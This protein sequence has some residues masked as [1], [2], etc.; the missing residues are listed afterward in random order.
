MLKVWT[1]VELFD[2]TS[3]SKFTTNCCQHD[4]HQQQLQHQQVLSWQF[5]TPGSHQSSLLNRTELVR[6]WVTDKH[7]QWSDSGPIKTNQIEHVYTES[8]IIHFLRSEPNQI[9]WATQYVVKFSRIFV[10]HITS[11]LFHTF[12]RSLSSFYSCSYANNSQHIQI[13]PGS[14]VQNIWFAR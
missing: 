10:I 12:P 13:G 5:H 1:K 11:P 9:F 6:E 3:A 2:Q 14:E 4:P 8:V 7:C